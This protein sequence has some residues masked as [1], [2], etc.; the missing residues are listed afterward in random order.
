MA[1][2]CRAVI[3]SSSDECMQKTSLKRFSV[4]PRYEGLDSYGWIG[5]CNA[6]GCGPG[7]YRRPPS[8]RILAGNIS[9]RALHSDEKRRAHFAPA[10]TPTT[11]GKSEEKGTFLKRFDSEVICT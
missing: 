7:A 9:E 8:Q 1:I 10:D 6:L 2:L 11:T 5:H 4:R 3:L